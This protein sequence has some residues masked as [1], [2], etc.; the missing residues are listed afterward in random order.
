MC[1]IDFEEA[2]SNYY[3]VIAESVPTKEECHDG[4]YICVLT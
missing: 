4:E 3:Q 2:I 1:L